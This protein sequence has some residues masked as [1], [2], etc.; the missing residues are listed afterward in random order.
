M[1]VIII[2]PFNANCIIPWCFDYGKTHSVHTDDY[3]HQQFITLNTFLCVISHDNL[4][5]DI[6]PFDMMT[7]WHG[8]ALLGLYEENP[9]VIPH[10]GPVI[11]SFEVFF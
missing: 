4:Q 11:W 1:I 6:F 9:L 10:K 7:E 3:C 8:N 5:R 2:T